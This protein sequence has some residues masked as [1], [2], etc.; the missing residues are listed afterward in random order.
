MSAEDT[1]RGGGYARLWAAA[2]RRLV[3][4][5]GALA[6][7]SLS[8]RDPTEAERRALGGLLGRELRGDS[9]RV[10][11]ADLDAALREGTGTGLLDWLTH[12]GGPLRDRPAEEAAREEAVASALAEARRSRLAGEGWFSRWLAA[13][14]GA[15]LTRLEREGSL[16]RLAEAVAVL[17]AL[18]APDLPLAL[19]A[20]RHAGGTKALRDTR[21]ARLVLGALAIR[22][23][24]PDPQRA[25]EVRALWERL[26]VFPDDLAA[27]V[28]VLNLP[29]TGD[30]PVDGM[31]RLGAA[32]GLPLRL[33]LHQLVRSPPTLAPALVSVCENPAVVRMAA[34]VHGPRCAPLVCTEGRPSSAFWRLMARVSGPVRARA[35]LDKEGLEIGGAVIARTGASPWRFDSATWRAHRGENQRLPERLPP[36]PWEP[37]LAEVMAGG[38]RV[39]EEE[40]MGVLVGDLGG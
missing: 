19:F 6:T 17:E 20:S 31:L 4:E 27:Q 24:L 25:E 2:R 12:V 9:L 35:D 30:G 32:S 5:P 23:E 26:G 29:A 39:E 11:L 28:L 22:E 3:R 15:P 18:P 21:L 38:V 37:G 33:T 14:E 10:S 1:L 34:E 40:L 7:A 36:T 8:L 13:L 16:G